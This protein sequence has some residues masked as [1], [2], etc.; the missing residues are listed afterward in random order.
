MKK[1][2]EID[3]L[4]RKFSRATLPGKGVR[5]KYYSRIA[6]GSNLVRLDPEVARLF[7]TEQAVNQAL[8]SLAEFSRKLPKLASRSTRSRAKAT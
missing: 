3:P 2:T 6:K 5:G 8:L 4:D 7:P 1:G